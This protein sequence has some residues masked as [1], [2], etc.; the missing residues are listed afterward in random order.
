[1][2]RKRLLCAVLALVLLLSAQPAA[3]A[4][5]NMRSTIFSSRVKMPVVRV[6]VPTR[7]QVYINPLRFPI[8]IGTEEPETGQI[9]TAPA[10]LANYSDA[11][12]QVDVAVTGGVKEGSDM[13]LASS[14]TQGSSGGSKRAF[15]YFEITTADSEDPAD[16]QWAS[17]YDPSKH[18]VVVDS[19][20]KTK[21]NAVTLSAKTLDGEV[22]PGGYAPFRLTGDAVENP[23]TAWNNKDGLVVQIAFTFT[24]LPYQ[25]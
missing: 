4:R 6:T 12:V 23:A 25:T 16:A 20:E 3:A 11:P 22:A 9:I 13:I 5:G 2:M 19:V 18:I 10:S 17:A 14:S 15:V 24:P 21:N 7:G 8:S 1:M